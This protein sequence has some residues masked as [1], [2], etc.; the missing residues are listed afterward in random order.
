MRRE[1]LHFHRGTLLLV[2]LVFGDLILGLRS[3]PGQFPGAP[4]LTSCLPGSVCCSFPPASSPAPRLSVPAKQTRH[5]AET[6]A[7]GSICTPWAQPHPAGI[8]VC[9][10]PSER[11][12]KL[13]T[14]VGKRLAVESNK[15]EIQSLVLLTGSSLENN[16][17][18][19][20]QSS[21]DSQV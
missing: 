16:L 1:V 18:M 20:R 21:E 9:H 4:S 3:K 13:K 8:R 12:V 2:A 15:L 7:D 17:C 19:H 14:R 11:R 10:P 5:P 6:K